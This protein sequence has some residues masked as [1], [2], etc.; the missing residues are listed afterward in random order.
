RCRTLGALATVCGSATLRTSSFNV[1]GS[2]SRLSL[3]WARQRCSSP[4]NLRVLKPSD[5]SGDSDALRAVLAAR[6]I[7]TEFARLE[8]EWQETFR[9]HEPRDFEFGLGCGIHTG[10]VT[11]GHIP[12]QFRDQFTA[13]G[14]PVNLASRLEARARSG[15]ILL[16]ESTARRI[17]SRIDLEEA[18]PLSDIKNIEGIYRVYRA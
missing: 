14:H 13:F 4:L 15:E 6:D 2:M 7:R 1:N 5:A 10:E 11:V 12:T 9:R 17:R 8:P 16:S 18:A 3:Q